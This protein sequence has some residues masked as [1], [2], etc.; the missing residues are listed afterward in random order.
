MKL[1]VR[2]LA[3]LSAAASTVA[4]ILMARW[5]R[6]WSVVTVVLLLALAWAATISVIDAFTIGRR[7]AAHAS[8]SGQRGHVTFVVRLGDEPVDIARTSI[9]LAAQAGPVV[10]VATKHHEML[11]DLGD[12]TV[13]EHVAPTIAEALHEAARSIDTESVLV[14]SASAFPLVEP[15]ER[16]AAQLTSG[17]GWVTGTTAVFNNDRYAPGARELMRAQVRAATRDLGL[18]TWEPDA[19]IVRTRLLREHPMVSGRPDGR[20]LRAIAADG[21]RGVAVSDVVAVRAAPTDAPVF[22]PTE[23]RRQCGTVADLA[24]ATTAGPLTARVLAAGALLRELY[25][26]PMLMWLTALV[27]IA[28]SGVSPLPFAPV[29]FFAVCGMLAAVR[30]ASSRLGYGVDLHPADEAREAAYDLPGSLLALPAALTRRV[31]PNGFGLPDQPLLWVALALTLLTTIPLLDRRSTDEG[32]VG[33]AV[34]L[35]LAA[36]VS[37]WTFA[38]RAFGVRGWDRASYRVA[39]EVPATLDGRSVRTLDASPCGLAVIGARPSLVRGSRVAVSVTFGATTSTL[40]GHVTDVRWVGDRTAVGLALELDPAQRV[41]WIHSLFGA[42]GLTGRGAIRRIAPAA[43]P[44]L[45]FDRVRPTARHRLAVGFQVAVVGAISALVCLALLSTFLGYRPMVV[46][47]GSMAPTL[48]IGDVVVADWERADR[49][50]TGEIVTFPY[51]VDG[52]DLVTHRVQTVDLGRDTVRIM[53]KGDANSTPEQWSVPRGTL[54]GRVVLTIPKVGTTLVVL[55]DSATRQLL[56]GVSA[57]V[58]LIGILQAFRRRVR[59]VAEGD[60]SAYEVSSRDL[61]GVSTD[62]RSEA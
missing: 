55:G 17:V 53:T 34:G 29:T 38:L 54:L 52:T 44:H 58:A 61:P 37:T 2:L 57:A 6:G 23:T 5:A 27:S 51:E 45:V 30:W 14:L 60:G 1:P 20:W 59:R 9:V 10:V 31:R 18:V 47:S 36:L 16:A 40:Q 24:D 11:D 25:A 13:R 39:I 35:A 12:A 46:R 7:P 41:A 15:C 50:Q 28:R 26:V 3:L 19:T 62:A 42:V 32:A 49:V 48:Q 4:V 43:R 56:L 22:W 8:P 33:I 21:W